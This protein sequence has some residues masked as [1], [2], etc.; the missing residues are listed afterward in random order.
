MKKIVLIV[1]S[2]LV[3]SSLYFPQSFA[4]SLNLEKEKYVFGETVKISGQVSFVEGNFIGLQI[5]NPSKSDI[6]VIDQF[7][8]QSDGKFTK[9]YKAQGPKWNENGFYLL[10]I[11]Y[12]DKVFEKQFFFEKPKKL[13]TEDIAVSEP[14]KDSDKEAS[15]EIE[16]TREIQFSDP[17][18][19]VDGFP[20]PSK[21]PSYYLERYYNEPAY[22][23][24]FDSVFRDYT[25]MEVVGYKTTHIEE[26]PDNTKSAWYYV[27]RYHNEENYRDWFDSQFPTKTIFEVLGYPESHFQKVPNWIKNN[28]KWWAAGLITDQDFL[29][30]IEFLIAEKIIFI[31]NLPEQ[32]TSQSNTVPEWIKNV[33][34][35]WADGLIDENEFLKGITFL[36]ENKIIEV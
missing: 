20:D 10:K 16:S 21:A 22:K 2:S 11:V 25:I 28:A 31:P 29:K 6:V 34:K 23:D 36:V 14:I 5:L 9:S 1:I 3:F 26:F 12:N 30:G 19:R 35:W 27:N 13:D 24:W 33:A 7:F 15:S 8:P 18:L 4:D 17:K 32:G